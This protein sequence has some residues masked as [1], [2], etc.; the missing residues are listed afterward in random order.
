ML[1]PNKH[2]SWAPLEFYAQVAGHQVRRRRK[3]FQ[4][5]VRHW[6][7]Y[8]HAISSL[9]TERVFVRRYGNGAKT[10]VK[11]PF[12]RLHLLRREFNHGRRNAVLRTTFAWP[13]SEFYAAVESA[14]EDDPSSCDRISRSVLISSSRETSLFLN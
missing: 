8:R 5:V 1:F 11:Q 13:V 9:K 10:G 7:K 2:F 14:S 12:H 4:A 3:H 6:R